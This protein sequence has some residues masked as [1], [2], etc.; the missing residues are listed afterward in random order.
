[1]STIL[2]CFTSPIGQHLFEGQGKRLFVEQLARAKGV[3]RDGLR[4]PQLSTKRMPSQSNPTQTSWPAASDIDH[5]DD[6]QTQSL[7]RFARQATRVNNCFQSPEFTLP[8]CTPMHR[9]SPA[10]LGLADRPATG[11]A[12]VCSQ[13]VSSLAN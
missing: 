10:S 2:I 8:G 1:M 11:G 6:L 7:L 9:L 3:R 4:W 13:A 5:A 12:P